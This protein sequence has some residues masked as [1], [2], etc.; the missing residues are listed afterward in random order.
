MFL[1]KHV[2]QIT[3]LLPQIEKYIFGEWGKQIRE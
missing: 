1:K 2:P 3:R